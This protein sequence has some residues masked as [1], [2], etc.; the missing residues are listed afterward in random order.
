M[1][2]LKKI[3]EFFSKP[4]EENVDKKY[5]D[6][7]VALRDSGVTNMFGAGPYLQAEFGLDKRE[8][9]EILANWMR[10]FGESLN[11]NV[12]VE[13]FKLE[14]ALK[15]MGHDV[16]VKA[17]D[18]F[19]K[20]VFEIY[21]NN[22]ADADDDSIFYDAKKL[23]YDNV[24]VFANPQE[25]LTENEDPIIVKYFKRGDE[26]FQILVKYEK[27]V[28]FTT[29]LGSRTALGQQND[30]NEAAA[31]KRIKTIVNNLKADFDL[32]EIF[33]EK[34]QVAG[35][36]YINAT[37]GDFVDMDVNDLE[38]YGS[39]LNEGKAYKTV[40]DKDGNTFKP[41]KKYKTQ[42]GIAKFI[43][44]SPDN[45][46]IHLK[47]DEKGLIKTSVDNAKNMELVGDV[48][49]DTQSELEKGKFSNEN[50]TELNSLNSLHK[51]IE[52]YYGR[53]LEPSQIT[54]ML[55][56]DNYIANLLSKYKKLSNESVNE[57]K[58]VTAEASK[59]ALNYFSDLKYEYQKAFRYLDVEEREEYKQLVKDFFSRLQID[60][61]V[62][63]V[64]LDE[65]NTGIYYKD[66]K[67][68]DRAKEASKSALG[69]VKDFIKKVI[70]EEEITVDDATEFKL[71]LKHLLD[72]HVVK[73]EEGY[74]QFLKT[75]DNPEGKTKGLD[76]ATMNKILMNVIKDLDE[77]KQ[78][79]EG[80][81]EEELCP[82]GKAYIKKRQAAGEKSSAYLSGR[83]VKV[84]KGQMKG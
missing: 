10:S 78:L 55:G 31:Q 18:D 60:N 17:V 21:F 30:Q 8:A 25:S 81:I 82:K 46:T 51:K 40:T 39:A 28:G 3:Q 20:N 49:E 27:P 23:G 36:Y 47:S 19:G 66:E 29:A 72:K 13:A 42:Y 16:K 70:K 74:S 71:N 32:D 50:A 4:L 56:K 7:L 41:N 75:D 11:E 22:P 65:Y 83:A 43:K 5:S 9:R 69:K 14:K 12:H 33:V 73:E 58:P 35:R 1:E 63:A 61:K 48:N 62:R 34:G 76:T 45:K 80:V 24:R 52:K 15:G 2:D 38:K 54:T 53:K 44:F 37:S 57:N 26:Y 84:C 59:G 77:L 79:G 6:F 64:G 68:Q 67:T